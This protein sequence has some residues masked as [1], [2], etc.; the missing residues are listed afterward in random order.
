VDP[1]GRASENL[2]EL[3]IHFGVTC[4]VMQL[5]QIVGGNQARAP[6]DYP[7]MNGTPYQLHRHLF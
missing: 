3:L 5:H 6:Q 1:E 7:G 2:F 4:G